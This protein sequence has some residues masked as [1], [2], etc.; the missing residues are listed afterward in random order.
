MQLRPGKSMQVQQAVS[1]VN[2]TKL[3]GRVA[4]VH[5]AVGLPLLGDGNPFKACSQG[6]WP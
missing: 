1:D 6:K 3:C 5:H 2:V 4:T